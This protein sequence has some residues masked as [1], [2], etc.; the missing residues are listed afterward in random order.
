M[1]RRFGFAAG[2]ALGAG[3]L[4]AQAPPPAP[5]ASPPTTPANA[6]FGGGREL[7]RLTGERFTENCGGCHGAPGTV[8]RA[9]NLFDQR[10][11]SAHNDEDLFR[12]VTKGIEGAEMPA[13]EEVLPTEQIWQ[14]IA[15]LRLE[16]ENTQPRPQF[17]A[18][19]AGAVIASEQQKFRIDVVAQG[20]ETPWGLAFLP[21]GRMLVTERAGQLR[22]IDRKGRLLP[23]AVKNTPPVWERQDAGLMD[24]AVDPDYR[25]AGWI[26]LSLVELKP[27][28]QL[29]PAPAL[30]PGE[31]PPNHPSMTVIVRGRLNKKGEW[32][33]AQTLFRAPL[34]R[35]TPSGVH[36]GSRLTFDPQ[37]RLLF[38]MGE[39]GDMKNAQDLSTPLGKLHRINRDGSIPADNPFVNRPGAVP[40]ILSWGHRN[41]QGL[42]HDAVGRLW[43]AEHGPSGGDEINLIQPGGNFG[44]GVVSM[45]IQPGIS[46]RAAP[47]MIGPVTYYTPTIAPS[48]IALYRGNRYPAWSGNLLVAGLAGQQLRRLVLDG[49]RITHQEVLF[50]SYGRVRAVTTGPDGLLYVLL[51]RPTGQGTGQPLSASTPGLV[52]KLEP[53]P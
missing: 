37:G 32:V 43:E 29:P 47:G 51:Q 22:I 3:L 30:K 41:P 31:R 21:D 1:I 48:G 33:D 45:G 40:S 36:Y 25:K 17:I 39:R 20:L 10:L 26:Y 4:S 11:L 16:A 14:L 2:L 38:S 18:D 24:V 8:G 15:W 44:W 53:L 6:G 27:G 7:Q 52:I 5:P 13:F 23:Q 46:A 12:I 9:P 50:K 19:P 34:D 28:Y 49:E 35:Y 42:A